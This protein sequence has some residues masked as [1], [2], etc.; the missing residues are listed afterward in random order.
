MKKPLAVLSLAVV[1]TVAG[2]VKAAC[3]DTLYLQSFQKIQKTYHV[4]K[5][6]AIDSTVETV[7]VRASEGLL[8]LSLFAPVDVPTTY[9]TLTDS[10]ALP[11]A[12]AAGCGDDGTSNVRMWHVVNAPSTNALGVA[13]R[14][15]TR[16]ESVRSLNVTR[17]STTYYLSGL[18]DTL[19][20]Q[21]FYKITP[22]GSSVLED[23]IGVLNADDSAVG[24]QVGAR[25][26]L[27]K[28]GSG[29]IRSFTTSACL[30]S[31]GLTYN[32]RSEADSLLAL[33]SQVTGGDYDSLQ[34]TVTGYATVYR[35]SALSYMASTTG[36]SRA[37]S[38]EPLRV[39]RTAAGWKLSSPVAAAGFIRDAS[40]RLLR[41]FPAG[42]SFTW[43][44]TV[45]G[46]AVHGVYLIGFEGRGARVLAVP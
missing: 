15:V 30:P 23:Y 16:S 19:K 5:S 25:A 18:G 26:V 1:A 33:K 42:T 36:I 35:T 32:M 38:R 22:V 46:A 45:S 10:A 3:T 40:G 13:T 37:T 6:G 20:F 12:F 34:V 39:I 31:T 4:Q 2:P 24:A 14:S 17:Q 8:D 7:P 44:G 29:S 28:S 43:D 41:S 11:V 9:T 27:Y 21:S